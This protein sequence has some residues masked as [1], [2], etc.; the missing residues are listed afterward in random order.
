MLYGDLEA[1]SEEPGKLVAPKPHKFIRIGR[2]EFIRADADSPRGSGLLRVTQA[3]VAE[4][5]RESTNTS[6]P[7]A[8]FHTFV[9]RTCKQAGADTRA[10]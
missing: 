8:L 10:D 9:L 2:R 7:M 5:T 4:V 3:A 6:P 1:D